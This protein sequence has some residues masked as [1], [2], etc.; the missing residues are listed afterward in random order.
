MVTVLIFNTYAQLMLY[1]LRTVFL[2]KFLFGRGGVIMPIKQKFN[3]L[4]D[5]YIKQ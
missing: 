5:K 1:I 2:K 3:K 4:C